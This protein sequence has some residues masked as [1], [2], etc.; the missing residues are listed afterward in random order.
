MRR[1]ARLLE[2]VFRLACRYAGQSPGFALFASEIR[3]ALAADVGR[4]RIQAYL[5]FLDKAMLVKL[6]PPLELRLKR[7]KGHAKICICDHGLRA[8]WLQEIVPLDPAALTRQPEYHDLAGHLA[9]SIVG[10]FLGGISHLDVGHFPERGDEPEV[11]YVL[12]IGEK[13]IP[14]EVKYRR[15]ID[16][17]RDT[18]GLRAFIEKRVYGAPFGILVTMGDNAIVDDPRIITVSLPALLLLR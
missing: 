4:Q 14:L 11:D 7:R 2:E 8:S 10:Y 12:S 15:R 3:Q 9:E 5:Q 17:M 16:P 1:D 6:I 13:R 18:V